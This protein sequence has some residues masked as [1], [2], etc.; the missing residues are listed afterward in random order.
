MALVLGTNCGFVTVAPT[1]DPAGS[2][3]QQDDRAYA[4]K[5]TSPVGATKITEFG[6]WCDG[7]TESSNFEIALYSHNAGTNRPNVILFSDLVNAK[8]TTAG[9]KS[10]AVDWNITAETTYW[11]AVQLDDTATATNTNYTA[12]AGQLV[13]YM[14]V[15]TQL[16]SPWV[17][18]GTTAYLVA[19]YAVWEAAAPPAGHPYYYQ[20]LLNRRA[21]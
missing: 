15:E 16:S 1:A 17:S 3:W 12:D 10:V 13:S 14:L 5:V 6:W 11:L 9:W 2:N 8:G 19:F 21:S 4:F 20:Q 7:A 18:E